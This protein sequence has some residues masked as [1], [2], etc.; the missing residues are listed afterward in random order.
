CVGGLG[1][2][3][4]G[5]GGVGGGALDRCGPTPLPMAR[6]LEEL[7]HAAV[8]PSLWPGLSAE[9]LSALRGPAA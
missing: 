6:M 5:V 3:V 9:D 4:G 8:P 7:L 1:G 2:G